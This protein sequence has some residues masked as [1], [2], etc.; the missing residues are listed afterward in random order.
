ML[1]IYYEENFNSILLVFLSDINVISI[2]GFLPSELEQLNLNENEKDLFFLN[3]AAYY[4]SFH[5]SIGF[6]C[7]YHTQQKNSHAKFECVLLDLK[8]KIR[9]VFRKIRWAYVN[10][11]IDGKLNF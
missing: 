9:S 2:Y 4:D 6:A 5:F 11:Y 3:Q 7:K 10:I 8:L 1:Q